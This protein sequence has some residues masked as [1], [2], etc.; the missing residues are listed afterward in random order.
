MTDASRYPAPTTQSTSQA[1]DHDRSSGQKCGY[2]ALMGL[3]NVGKSTLMNQILG[4]KV[5]IVSKRPQTTRFQVMGIHCVGDD[6]IIF[7]DTPGVFDPKS[8]FEKNILQAAWQAV[9]DCAVV[10]LLVDA[11]EGLSPRTEGLLREIARRELRVVVVLNKIDLIPKTLLLSLAK[12][13]YEMGCV[14]DIFMISALSG[15]GVKDFVAYC[16][17]KLPEGPWCFQEDQLTNL[18]MRFMASELTR[19]KLFTFLNKELPYDLMVETDRWE[20]NATDIKVYQ[21]IYVKRE[22][23]R[24]IILGNKG[25]GIKRIGQLSRHELQEMT[26]K[27]VHLFLHVKVDKLWHQKPHIFQLG[28]LFS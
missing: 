28:H 22:S 19:E 2:V 25:M 17:K 20:E 16:Q 9:H 23:Q 3:P 5:S 4:T 6:Q 15:S 12:S 8:P 27:A 13:I 1:D 26:G 18:P 10:A 7:M 21:T 24:G 11:K 14:E